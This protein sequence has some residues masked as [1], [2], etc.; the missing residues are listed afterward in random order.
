MIA[1]ILSHLLQWIRATSSVIKQS[2]VSMSRYTPFLEKS[3]RTAVSIRKPLLAPKH[4]NL[5]P[6]FLLIGEIGSKLPNI[7]W[8]NAATAGSWLNSRE[9]T[10]SQILPLEKL[11]TQEIELSASYIL[12]HTPWQKLIRIECD[13]NIPQQPMLDSISNMLDIASTPSTLLSNRNCQYSCQK[14]ELPQQDGRFS[15]F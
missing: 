4:K 3:W 9:F 7:S 12:P 1:E 2:T 8:F 14:S 6:I 10:F 15:E 11:L 13:Y 5:Q